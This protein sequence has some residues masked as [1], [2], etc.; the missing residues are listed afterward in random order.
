LLSFVS[1]PA[2]P[3]DRDSYLYIEDGIVVVRDGRI[4]AVG[5]ASE[6]AA[7]L[8]AGTP[9]DHHP[10]GLIVPGF[11]DTHIHFPQTQV[12]ASYGAQLL[13]WLNKYTFVEEQRFAD[14][15][16][17]E[18][19][20]VFFMDE[21]LRNGTTTA[22][23]Y[24]TVHPGSVEAFFAESERRG[25]AMIAGKV[26]MDRNAP[27]GLQDTAQASY[28]E[29]RAL[30]E[31]WHG[32]GRQRY[33]V[34]PRFAITSTEAQLEAAGALHRKLRAFICRRTCR[35]IG[36]RSRRCAS[37]SRM[38]ATTRMSTTATDCWAS[39]RCSAIASIWRTT[40]SGGCRRAGRSRCSARRPICSSAAGCST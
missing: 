37:F 19:N 6:L 16:H 22:V 38:L 25:T 13:E 2:G 28:D 7:T 17:A 20:A 34:T 31:R 10:D 4:E 24:A 35:K 39:G 32:K 33:A 30:I 8:P 18:R 27:P 12:I 9:V 11:I 36:P 21:L 14:A 3:G 29:S 5:E 26:M 40:K 1:E 15:G 23:V